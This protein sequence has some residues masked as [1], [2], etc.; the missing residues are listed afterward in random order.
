LSKLNRG[1]RATHTEEITV[2]RPT[3]LGSA[4]SEWKW[5][6]CERYLLN[7]GS[8]RLLAKRICPLPEGQAAVAADLLARL[9]LLCDAYRRLLHE[10]ELEHHTQV[11][12][13]SIWKMESELRQYLIPEEQRRTDNPFLLVS[14]RPLNAATPG[15]AT[16]SK[17]MA[18]RGRSYAGDIPVR[19]QFSLVG[20]FNLAVGA[21]LFVRKSRR[22]V[23]NIGGRTLAGNGKGRRPALSVGLNEYPLLLDFYFSP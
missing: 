11:S 10:Q 13:E 9:L 6:K 17:P 18:H 20:T 2:G 21:G 7:P 8:L 14:P 1:T 3:E 5:V 4:K 12:T 16:K 15:V 23:F 19:V 22:F